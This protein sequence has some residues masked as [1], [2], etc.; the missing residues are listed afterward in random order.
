MEDLHQRKLA[1]KAFLESSG[2]RL[3]AEEV[4]M[5]TEDLKNKTEKM[6]QKPLTADEMQT[7][8]FKL[9]TK[10]GIQVILNILENFK[11]ELLDNSSS[12]TLTDKE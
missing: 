4:A 7:L 2:F 12:Q 11:Q 6:L 9:G 10:N 5:H 8:N 3:F 1:I